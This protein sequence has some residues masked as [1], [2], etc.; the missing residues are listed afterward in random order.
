MDII[1]RQVC[2]KD[3]E[4][5]Q[6]VAVKDGKIAAIMPRF[7]GNASRELQADGR[8]LLP[9][10]IESHLHLEKAL[11]M[12]RKANR[13]GTL[14][15]AIAVSAALKPTF[16]REDILERA[17]KALRMMVGYG[18]TWVRAH[19]EFDPAQGFTGVDAVL[20]LKEEFK[21]IIDI[22]ITAF[23]QE[24]ILK[25]PG[26]E[27]MMHEAVKRGCSVVGGIPYND[28]NAEEHIDLV[29]GIAKQYDLDLDFHQDFSDNADKMSI[30]YLARKTIEN[31]Y[32][33]RVSVGHLTSLGAVPPEK[34]KD[35]VALIRDAGISVMCLPMTDLHLGARNDA[36][37]VRR[38]L[39][40]VR[41]LRDGGVNVCLA[42]NNIRNAFTPFGNGDLFQ[43]AMLAIPA[44]HL[45]GADD[46]A[47]V[48][49]MITT[50]AAKALKL[51]N[52]G[53]AEGND[54]DLVLIDAKKTTEAIID[55]PDR[56][57]VVKRGKIVV[58]SQR[59]ALYA[60]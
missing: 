40:P 37:N 49:P 16:T 23:P 2:I 20:L 13:S 17:R 22:Q 47:T 46:Q 10:L 38:T 33:G 50:N 4:P 35:I 39:T 12:D 32:E 51:K 58:E 41:A 27:E 15:E 25:A 8:V 19:S 30:E 48:L 18:S 34:L 29:F 11:I 1:L 28:T 42:S 56:L 3:N 26:T 14:Q 5:L 53:L 55:M 31:K 57:L 9:G 60:F 6:D 21:D 43:V 54:A 24:G 52:Y 59:T 7:A 45:G 36:Y 44:C